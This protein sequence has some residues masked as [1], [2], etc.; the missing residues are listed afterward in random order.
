MIIGDETG[1][2][3]NT[4]IY[5]FDK[6]M[7]LK[8]L[9]RKNRNL[10]FSKD[11]EKHYKKVYPFFEQTA[12]IEMLIPFQNNCE[13]IQNT[14]KPLFFQIKNKTNTIELKLKFYVANASDNNQ[15]TQKLTAESGTIKTTINIIK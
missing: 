1:I 10:E 8:D 7:E 11:F 9:A 6:T 4:G 2:K 14:P 3:R 13:Y 12:N 5:L 15:Y